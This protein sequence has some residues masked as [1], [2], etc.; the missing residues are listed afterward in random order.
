MEQVHTSK[1]SIFSIRSF[2]KHLIVLTLRFLFVSKSSSFKL[3]LSS[4]LMEG[5]VILKPKIFLLIL[6]EFPGTQ[7]I[8]V[9]VFFSTHIEGI[10][11]SMP[12]KG[13]VLNKPQ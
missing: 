9:L 6:E 13:E 8:S 5:P 10:F 4:V 12:T 3:K 1:E 11:S 2:S 7:L